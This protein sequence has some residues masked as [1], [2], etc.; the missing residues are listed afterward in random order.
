[1][2]KKAL[3]IGINDYPGTGSDLSGC[4][5]DAED[6]AAELTARGFATKK[7]LDSAATK[8]GMVAAIEALVKDARGGDS[9]VITFSGHGT[10]AP[11][12]DGDDPDGLDE[13]LCPH[14]IRSAGALIDDEI[15]RLFAGRAPGVRILLI[16]DSCHSGTV[17]RAAPPDPDAQAAR[18]R[19]L[20]MGAW[21]PEAAL[22]RAADGRPL[23]RVALGTTT[24]PWAGAISL[25]S[26]EDLLLAGCEEGPNNFSY[27]ASFRGRPNGAFTYY[28]LKTLRKLDAKATYATWHNEIR[29]QLPSASYPQTPQIFGSK[30]AQADKVLA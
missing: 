21:L 5:N 8:A 4:V 6:W 15:H 10:Y 11:D 30:R 27:D 26:G 7:L 25:A 18:P 22:P 23:S 1:M 14:D 13:A 29:K 24:S 9:V 16:S 12:R 19:F 28:A 3:C 20:P 17:T 2:A